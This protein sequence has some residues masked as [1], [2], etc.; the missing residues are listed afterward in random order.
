[1][2]TDDEQHAAR[3]EEWYASPA[4]T[5]LLA[6]QK[7]LL[8]QGLGPWPQTGRTL[9]EVNCGLGLLEPGLRAMGLDVTGCEGSPALRERFS[10]RLG[11]TF[12]VDPAKA[13]LL[14][15]GDAS[16]DWVLLRLEH[17]EEDCGKE[18][19]LRALLQEARRVALKGLA[20]LVWNRCSLPA[21]LD[22]RHKICAR[23]ISSLRVF[24]ELVSLREGR[25][26][27]RGA[28]YLP[29]C[30]WPFVRA[31][32]SGEATGRQGCLRQLADCVLDHVP[33]G[34]FGGLCLVCLELPPSRPMT[35]RP[36]RFLSPGVS[37]RSC[38]A[39]EVSC[40]RTE[41][42]SGVLARGPC[43]QDSAKNVDSCP[44]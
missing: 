2:M 35:A 12:V 16:F 40:Q 1:M 36:L 29:M 7:R 37:I 11:Y 15:Y 17:W 33:L 27:V 32:A 10:L 8:A 31:R 22:P 18:E 4:G 41:A 42:G 23:P 21:L 25:V 20:V 24:R 14:P 6:A 43:P 34:L 19:T 3:L 9:L 26:R 38:T 39:K 13:D 30:L 28:L 44:M 5:S